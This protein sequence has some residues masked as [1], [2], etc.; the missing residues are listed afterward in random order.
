MNKYSKL[1]LQKK[2]GLTYSKL[3]KGI[4]ISWND[5]PTV[6]NISDSRKIYTDDTIAYL[7][8]EFPELFK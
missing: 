2:T 3:E 6:R 8:K 1:D 4:L 5:L 7:K